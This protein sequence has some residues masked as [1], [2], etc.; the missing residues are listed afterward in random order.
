M[1]SLLPKMPLMFF[2]L[3]PPKKRMTGSSF[4]A[5]LFTASSLSGASFA[6]SIF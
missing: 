2:G 1:A 4:T 5:S 6:P 3:L